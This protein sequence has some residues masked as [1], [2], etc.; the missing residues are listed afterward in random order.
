MRYIVAF[1]L[2]FICCSRDWQDLNRTI[3]RQ[4]GQYHIEL[5]SG[6]K[7]IFQDDF[8]GVVNQE[9]GTDGVMYIKGDTMIELCGQYVIKQT[10]K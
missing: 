9:T 6:G 1:C 3:S 7:I 10:T 8:Y 5:Y 4:H 2:L